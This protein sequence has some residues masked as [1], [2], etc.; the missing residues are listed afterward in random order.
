MRVYYDRDADVNLIKSKKVAIIGY[1]SQ[2]HA[3]A[4]NLKDSGVTEMVIGLRPGSSAVAKAEG[5]GFKVMDPSAAAAWADVVMV[6]TPDEGQGAL[7]KEHLEANLK[8]GA[9][10]AFAH[11]LSIHFRIIEA[12]PDLDVFLIAPKGPGHTV[13]SEYQRGGGVPSL[14]AVAQNASGNALEIA[15]S[16]AS[17]N[18][19]GRAG[20]IETTFKEEVETDLFGEQAVLCGGLVELIRAGFETLVEAGYAPEMAYF[21]CLHETKLIVDLI[22][23][24]G[25]AN[26]NYSISN[27]AEYGEYVTGPR[28][29]TSETKAEM[30]RV[31]TDIQDGTFVRNFILENQSGNVG[32]KAIRARNNAHQIEQVGE[33]LRAM[34]PWIGKNALVDK[35]RN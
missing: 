17:A 7:Y 18:G 19:G 5:A 11:G 27:T 14:V 6:L 24:G 10:L 3:H 30:K 1:G 8:Q 21:E 31:L 29:V 2:G 26:M 25:I 16:Y 4:N 34:M 12:R 35:T 33:K 9:A 32:F 20:I 23:E 15:L 13:R 28:I 22:Y